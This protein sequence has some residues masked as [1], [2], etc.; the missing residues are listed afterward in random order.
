[1]I[2]ITI[3]LI[4]IGLAHLLPILSSAVAFIFKIVIGSIFLGFIT[5]INS[6]QIL[7]KKW[8]TWLIQLP[9]LCFQITTFIGTYKENHVWFGIILIILLQMIS[10]L[11]I[12]NIQRIIKG[13]D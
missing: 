8:W 13:E 5:M 2:Y 3:I 7:T 12:F 10:S 4:I 1:M 6:L 9:I 11:I